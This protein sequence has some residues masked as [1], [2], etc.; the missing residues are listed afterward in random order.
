MYGALLQK[1]LNPKQ[2]F[3]LTCRVVHRFYRKHASGL[4]PEHQLGIFELLMGQ[5][6]EHKRFSNLVDI[7]VVYADVCFMTKSSMAD[8]G[9]LQ[10]GVK[11]EQS[12]CQDMAYNLYRFS[13]A[14]EAKGLFREAANVYDDIAL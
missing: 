8:A 1:L 3:T 4:H 2:C 5:Y 12:I 10:L 6:L 7:A 13:E 11:N 14:M 9:D